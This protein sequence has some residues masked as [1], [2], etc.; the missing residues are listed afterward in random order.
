MANHLLSKDAVFYQEA[1]RRKRFSIPSP[2]D[3]EFEKQLKRIQLARIR[4]KHAFHSPVSFLSEILYE[5]F[6]E[7]AEEYKLETPSRLYENEDFSL[8]QVEQAITAMKNLLI[9]AVIRSQE[10]NR[11]IVT[12]VEAYFHNQ[13]HDDVSQND[14]AY[15]YPREL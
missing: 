15:A 9:H 12:Q 4:M 1:E 2:V 5:K 8:E 6:P 3:E 7:L 10:N 14:P 11:M 13:N